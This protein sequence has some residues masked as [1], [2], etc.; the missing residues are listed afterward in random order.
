MLRGLY[1]C[2][3]RIPVLYTRVRLLVL[4]AVFTVEGPPSNICADVFRARLHMQVR[5]VVS[6]ILQDRSEVKRLSEELQ[7]E[8]ER[9]RAAEE[10]HRSR[11]LQAESNCR[12]RS[13]WC[14][15]ID[16]TFWESAGI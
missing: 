9:A 12:V 4:I 6:G 5:D 2:S 14:P 8:K 11:L 16:R 13:E 3:L 15:M 10:L 1:G 7:Q